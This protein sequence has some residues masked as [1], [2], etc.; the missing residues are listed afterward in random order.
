MN[1]AIIGDS[2]GVPVP[3]IHTNHTQQVLEK[4]GYDVVN[5][6]NIGGANIPSIKKCFSHCTNN[7]IDLIIWFHTDFLREVT[8]F[9]FN[10]NN[11]EFIKENH[12]INL[13]EI[14]HSISIKT[15]KEFEKLRNFSGAKVI[16]IGGQ[17]KILDNF[18]EYSNADFLIKDWR[19]EILQIESVDN[20][21]LYFNNLV[22]SNNNTMSNKEKFIIMKHFVKIFRELKKSPLFP[23]N[24]HTGDEPHIEL[25]NKIHKFIQED[26]KK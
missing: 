2:W 16:I 10:T 12:K 20:S 1:I 18:F 19:S 9:N 4:F 26:I 6:S 21:M 3:N 25:A 7:K 11:R 5:F 13:F 8:F 15:Y 23:D 14:I 24:H 17:A 22:H